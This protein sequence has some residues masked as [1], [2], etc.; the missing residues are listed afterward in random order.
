VE[1]VIIIIV[2]VWHRKCHLMCHLMWQFMEYEKICTL[3]LLCEQDFDYDRAIKM[4]N[5]QHYG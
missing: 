4:G 5:A 1:P 3:L 2:V